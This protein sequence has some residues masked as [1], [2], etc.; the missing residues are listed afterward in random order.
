MLSCELSPGSGRGFCL[1]SKEAT[2]ELQGCNWNLCWNG[3]RGR[4]S[5]RLARASVVCKVL[6]SKGAKYVSRGGDVVSIEGTDPPTRLTIIEFPN[7][8]KA[9][10]VFT[11]SEYEDARK[12]GQVRKIQNSRYG[13][14]RSIENKIN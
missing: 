10:Q 7:I 8:D 12:I 3:Y 1:L 2:N 13:G 9:K 6:E 14:S 11:S 4:G 5:S